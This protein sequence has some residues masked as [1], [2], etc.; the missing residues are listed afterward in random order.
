MSTAQR[1]P[2]AANGLSFGRLLLAILFATLAF[3]PVP[4]ALLASIY[5]L[6]ALSDILDGVLARRF[7]TESYFG[8]VVDLVSDKSL[9]IVSLLFAAARGVVIVPLAIIGVR[10]MVMMGMRLIVP[11]RVPLLGTSRL[12]GGAMAFLLWGITAV[13]ILKG[14]DPIW[15]RMVERAYLIAALA[16]LANLI[17]RIHA[18]LDRIKALLDRSEDSG[19]RP[20]VP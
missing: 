3:Q 15:F 16:F 2:Q 4:V 14:Y 19:Q 18:N 7:A 20:P 1:W 8:K 11:E 5:G 9:T 12:F 10:E 6:A 17:W 13:L